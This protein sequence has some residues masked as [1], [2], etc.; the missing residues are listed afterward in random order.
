MLLYHS[1]GLHGLDDSTADVKLL[2]QALVKAKK[3]VPVTGKM[4]DATVA[5]VWFVVGS[6]VVKAQNIAKLVSPDVAQAIGY[7]VSTKNYID[8]AVAEIYGFTT[9]RVIKYWSTINDIGG[10]AC[11]LTN[12]DTC[13][14]VVDK[15]VAANKTMLDTLTKAA[16]GL[17]KF[18]T[19][20]NGGSTSTGTTSTST[21]TTSVK[22][23]I[24]T[25]ALKLL[26][27]K[28]KVTNAPLV[29]ITPKPGLVLPVAAAPAA[30]TWWVW[31]ALGL[32]GG[33]LLARRRAA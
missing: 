30:I 17:A 5:A 26:N 6:D 2:Q 20:F 7:I 1:V 33:T 28:A 10:A 12:S 24:A 32:V 18:I 16:S 21:G 29:M 11:S 22:T 31:A 25:S 27:T 23:S 14:A 8:G 3:S 9:E 15:L 13:R 19:M 4:D